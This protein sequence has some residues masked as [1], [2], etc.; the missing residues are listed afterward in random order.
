MR[1]SGRPGWD[2]EGGAQAEDRG[3]R[4]AQ[5]V[6]DEGEELVLVGL[7]VVGGGDVA[8]DALEAHQLALLG[9]RHGGDVE[10]AAHAVGPDD[11]Q[12]ESL[13]APA[14]AGSSDS[15]TPVDGDEHVGEQRALELVE[16]AARG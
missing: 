15:E 3:Q 2:L 8:G 9:A 12:L 5:V 1:S 6:G 14:T 16:A 10:H 11:G 4:V 7:E 13:G